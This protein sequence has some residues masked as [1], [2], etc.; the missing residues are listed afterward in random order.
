MAE[1]KITNALRPTKKERNAHRIEITCVEIPGSPDQYKVQVTPKQKRDEPGK[2]TKGCGGW[3][4]PFERLFEG[5]DA[6]D[7][8]L[9]YVKEIL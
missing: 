8:V 3:T 4:N 1:D 9:A 5:K 6:E 7:R 2:E